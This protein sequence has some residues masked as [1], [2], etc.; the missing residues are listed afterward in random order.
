MKLKEKIDQPVTTRFRDM[1]DPEQINF[2]LLVLSVSYNAVNHGQSPG[3]VT[4]PLV[5]SELVIAPANP[6]PVLL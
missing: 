2:K 1:S 5:I 3:S 4:S 6:H